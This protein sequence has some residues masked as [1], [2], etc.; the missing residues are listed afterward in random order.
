ME[1]YVF[2]YKEQN[3]DDRDCVA[4]I[5]LKTLKKRNFDINNHVNIHGSCYSMGF[6]ADIPYS[7]VETILTE[8]EYY[9]LG[10]N[11]LK[12]DLGSIITKLLSKENE[13]LFRK[14][15]NEEWEYL[16]SHYDL[17]S[18]DIELI[19]ET[20]SLEYRDRSVVSCIFKDFN[21]MAQEE[22]WQLGYVNDENDRYFDYK[23]F[24]NDL[25]DGDSYVEITDD[26][27]VYL[28]Y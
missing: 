22:A 7:K 8:Q 4:Y 25:L 13:K 3:T 2:F 1:R 23:K 19:F 10:K 14:I 20:Y 5:D 24:G 11:P 9:Q 18:K 27:I 21:D 15:K 6:K 17:T 26:R 28:S 16:Y 12:A